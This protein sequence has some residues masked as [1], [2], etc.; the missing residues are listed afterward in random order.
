VIDRLRGALRDDT[1]R[2]LRALLERLVEETSPGE[3]VA[4]LDL[5]IAS[6]QDDDS[7]AVGLNA[8]VRRLSPE[9]LDKALQKIAA[10]VTQAKSPEGVHLF[11]PALRVVA[12]GATPAEAAKASD[13]IM[14]AIREA[15]KGTDESHARRMLGP[16]ADA[17]AV[18]PG[19]LDPEDGRWLLASLES[20]ISEYRSE[21]GPALVALVGRMDTE[22]ARKALKEDFEKVSTDHTT[23]TERA[24][25]IGYLAEA[26]GRLPGSMPPE[27]A[28][29]IFETIIEAG[30]RG[31]ISPEELE[32][33]TRGATAIAQKIGP[34]TGDII[35]EKLLATIASTPEDAASLEWLKALAEIFVV[36]PGER[37]RTHTIRNLWT[38]ITSELLQSG[39]HYLEESLTAAVRGL[40]GGPDPKELIQAL[41][42]LDEDQF[43]DP[44]GNENMLLPLL[45]KVEPRGVSMVTDALLMKKL[46]GG[47]DDHSA[48]TFACWMKGLAALHGDL[49]MSKLEGLF[50]TT[51]NFLEATKDDAEVQTD[52]AAQWT[53]VA[54]KIAPAEA[55]VWIQKLVMA[56]R[57]NDSVA[58]LSMSAL[59]RAAA[60]VEPARAQATFEQLAR[61]ITYSESPKTLAAIAESVRV[62][63]G[64]L[65]PQGLIDLLKQP[66]C[67]GPLRSAAL[68][69]LER[70]AGQPF[71]GNVWAA[72]SWARAHRLDVESPPISPF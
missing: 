14:K 33:L 8:V 4:T 5:L 63:P 11:V 67:V 64:P 23:I 71:D 26:R 54:G 30:R 2:S 41:N 17:L 51:Q 36:L 61:I 27:E 72:V 68:A 39:S 65:E 3:A 12:A 62:L 57:S 1:R 69:Q 42:R 58:T 6:G 48:S 43:W 44:C 15:S 40:P 53:A 19:K 52:L 46:V 29:V 31:A 10:A 66:Y 21:S 37:E 16:W 20:T 18:V 24:K 55:H 7:Q 32:I 59:P 13:A 22:T 45:E 60:R 38:A 35:A 50:T 47:P 34:E 56:N 25:A 28:Q 9:D 70:V 49:P